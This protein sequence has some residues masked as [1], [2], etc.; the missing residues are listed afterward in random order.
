MVVSLF[1]SAE[2]TLTS[3]VGVDE[4]VLR[5]LAWGGVLGGACAIV[6]FFF[7]RG[8]LVEGEHP[9]ESSEPILRSLKRIKG[10]TN[11]KV[12]MRKVVSISYA[13]RRLRHTGI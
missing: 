6:A 12:Q 3:P 4:L 7:P 10:V 9:L 11:V 1:A 13:P 8:M 5:F 2:L